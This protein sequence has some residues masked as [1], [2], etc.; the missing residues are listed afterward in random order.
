MITIQCR[1]LDCPNIENDSA[2]I[3]KILIQ[4]SQSQQRITY[5]LTTVASM[6]TLILEEQEEYSL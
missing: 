6:I 2:L 4:V 3:G 5:S 1:Y